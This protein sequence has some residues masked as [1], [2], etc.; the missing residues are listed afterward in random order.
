MTALFDFFKKS[1]SREGSRQRSGKQIPES[2][3]KV[4]P[5]KKQIPKVEPVKKPSPK[6]KDFRE[7]YKI[8]KEPHISE[9]STQLADERKY[10]FKV[11]AQANKIQIKKAISNLYG[12]RVQDVNIINIKSKKR[13]LRGAE[14]RKAG[15]KKAVVTLREGE[16]IEILPH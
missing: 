7:V 6:K 14:G 15:Y 5:T 1:R 8:L 4:K 9:K 16:K 3:E 13:I 12:A 10:T 2:K 11:Y